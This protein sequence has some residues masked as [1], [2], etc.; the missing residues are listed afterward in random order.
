MIKQKL[1]KNLYKCI[2]KI[3]KIIKFNINL[4]KIK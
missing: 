4:E 1:S 2:G 3:N